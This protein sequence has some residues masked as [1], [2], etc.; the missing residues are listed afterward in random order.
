[1]LRQDQF[2]NWPEFHGSL[3]LYTERD[4]IYFKIPE[5]EHQYCLVLYNNKNVEKGIYRS[6]GPGA[7]S[8][9]EYG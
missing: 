3:L 2:G 8:V 6:M 4:A 7:G 5:K 9:Q 1:M